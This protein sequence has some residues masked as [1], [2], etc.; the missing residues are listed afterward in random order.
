MEPMVKWELHARVIEA[1]AAYNN[2]VVVDH[3]SGKYLGVIRHVVGDEGFEG[4]S[5]KATG[6]KTWSAPQRHAAQALALL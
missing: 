4:W 6:T 5:V 1:D 2:W 3:Q